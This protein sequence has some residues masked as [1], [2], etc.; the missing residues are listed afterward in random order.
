MWE[1]DNKKGWVLKWWCLQTVMPEKTLEIP[2]DSKEIKPV[3]PK[4]NQSWTFIGRT[5]AEAETPVFWPSDGKNWLI[6]K[7]PDAG[8]D[9]RQE[10]KGMTEYEMVGG[11]TDSMD[12]SLINLWKMVKDRKTWHAAVPGIAKS[13]ARLSNWTTKTNSV[14]AGLWRLIP[15][16][17]ILLPGS[18]VNQFTQVF[19][20]VW[21]ISEFVKHY[22]YPH[23][24]FVERWFY[25][26]L[27]S[28]SSCILNDCSFIY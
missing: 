25:D 1:L 12:M 11:I 23:F 27:K 22:S 18:S 4:G 10:E 20:S 21:T 8:K 6:G 5:D 28:T 17:P 14:G 24:H 16:A 7:D 19:Q 3:H 2:L 26:H 15:Q 13:W 9:W